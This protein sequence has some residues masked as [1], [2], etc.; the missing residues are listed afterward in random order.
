MLIG[1]PNRRA[2]ERVER[3]LAENAIPHVSWYEP[4][5]DLGFTSIATVPLTREEKECLAHYRLW[6]DNL[7]PRS[8]DVERPATRKNCGETVLRMHPGEPVSLMAP[9]A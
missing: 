4:D 1:I 7:L 6:S 8:L 2:L 5:G 9:E 3:R